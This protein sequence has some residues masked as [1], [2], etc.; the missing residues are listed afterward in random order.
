MWTDFNGETAQSCRDIASDTQPKFKG[1]K[2]AV[3]EPTEAR[4]TKTGG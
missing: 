1:C 2:F 4:A 3:I